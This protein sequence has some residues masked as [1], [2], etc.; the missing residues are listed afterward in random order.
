[1]KRGNNFKEEMPSNE[2]PY[3]SQYKLIEEINLRRG[4]EPVMARDISGH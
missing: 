2:G 3:R 4:K 1:M